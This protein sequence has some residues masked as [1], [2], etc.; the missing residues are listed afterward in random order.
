[1][2]EERLFAVFAGLFALVALAWAWWR[3]FR[4]QVVGSVRARSQGDGRIAGR[5]RAIVKRYG[6]G[7]R[8]VA[9]VELR[10]AALDGARVFTFT[11]EVA[12]YVAANLEKAVERIRAP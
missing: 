5:A 1:V 8:D 10:V 3:F 12:R 6:K 2:S 7:E 4:G 9:A 11:P